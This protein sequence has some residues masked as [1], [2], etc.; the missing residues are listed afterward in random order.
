MERNVFS[1]RF[2]FCPACGGLT[3]YAPTTELTR[4]EHEMLLSFRDCKCKKP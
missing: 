2:E 3:A 1:S 4:E